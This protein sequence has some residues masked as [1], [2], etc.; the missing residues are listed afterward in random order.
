MKL[1]NETKVGIVVFFTGIIFFGGIMYMR[2]ISFGGKEHSLVVMYG[3]VNGL[4]EGNPVTIAGYTIGK[5]SSIALAGTQIAV[6]VSIENDVH[7]TDQAKAEIKSASLMGGKLIAVTPSDQGR[8]LR[9]GDTL[10]GTYE[11]D[12]SELTSTLAPIGSDV[13]GILDKVNATFNETTRQGIQN[14]VQDVGRA[15]KQVNTIVDVQGN[16]LDRVLN[17]FSIVSAVLVRFSQRLDTMAGA[18]RATLDSSMAAIHAMTENLH[19]AAMHIQSTTQSLDTVIGRVERGEGT[20][21]HIMSDDALYY[22]IDSV[23]VN[24]NGVLRDM[25]DT[26]G[27]YI[28]FSIF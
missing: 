7:L 28:R 10:R 16:K 4:K 24:L 19:Q 25:R 18:Q 23:A 3:N 20:L 14:I 5:V 13:L 17:N 1:N 2:D 8:V 6:G 26:P 15:S 27:K 21:G 12:L 11:A 22:H 9:S